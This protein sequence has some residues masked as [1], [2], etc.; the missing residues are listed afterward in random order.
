MNFFLKNRF[1]FTPYIVLRNEI[2]NENNANEIQ[3]QLEKIM[4]KVDVYMK[5]LKKWNSYLKLI[6][7]I[8][9]IQNFKVSSYNHLIDS[10]ISNLICGTETHF[11]IYN[12]SRNDCNKIDI[13]FFKSDY[14]TEY[15]L[16][17][18]LKE[19]PDTNDTL[20]IQTGKPFYMVHYLPYNM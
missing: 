15:N 13:G 8:C 11:E 18:I 12:A 2:I 20:K 16:E 9:K 1:Y 10:K 4:H 14:I 17:E 7:T 5:D 19:E 6:R 3:N